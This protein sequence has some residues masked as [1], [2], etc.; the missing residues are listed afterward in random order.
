MAGGAPYIFSGEGHWGKQADSPRRA[1][2]GSGPTGEGWGPT[3]TRCRACHHRGRGGGGTKGSGAALQSR[4]DRSPCPPL[5]P[6]GRRAFG[7]K[8]TQ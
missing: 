2:E 5:P 4:R 3:G 1:R 6:G 8:E 7:G